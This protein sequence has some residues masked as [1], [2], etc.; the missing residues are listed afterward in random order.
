MDNTLKL[1]Q[2]NAGRRVGSAS[3]LI[4]WEKM[5]IFLIQEPEMRKKE[6]LHMHSGTLFQSNKKSQTQPPR[7]AIFVKTKACMALNPH[8]IEQFS[9]H[10][11]TTIKIKIPWEEDFD[12]EI[13]ICSVYCPHLDKNKKHLNDPL[14]ET[15]KKLV[16]NCSD[17]NTE[18]LISMDSNSHS[19]VWSHPSDNT[20]GRNLVN[21][22]ANTNLVLL[23][24]GSTPTFHNGYHESF[25]D[26]TLATPL[27]ASRINGWMAD[28][29][30]CISDHRPILFSL[31]VAITRDFLKKTKRK[32][33]WRKYERMCDTR[34]AT[35]PDEISTLH[36]LEHWAKFLEST[37]IESLNVCSKEV[38]IK[39]VYHNEWYTDH[40][41]KAKFEMVKANGRMV[42]ENKNTVAG[43]NLRNTFKEKRKIYVKLRRK[44][45]TNLYRRSASEW[46]DPGVIAKRQRF[47]SQVVKSAWEQSRK[48]TGSLQQVT[49]IP[50]KS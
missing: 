50:T 16:K 44:A 29:S 22:I 27:L 4:K 33:D 19:H 9:Y 35:F 28:D 12:K 17:S 43:L 1:L 14:N 48:L 39:D 23:N 7:T 46:N 32:N 36:D 21:F 24:S 13:L 30:A 47:L 25:I 11:M 2:I 15:F 3:E 6:I 31:D 34:L 5:D 38:P 10:D 42:A 41:K 8:I 45:K 20:R 18:L 49:K 40:L 26:I 37:L